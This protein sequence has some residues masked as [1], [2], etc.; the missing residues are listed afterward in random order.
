M[1]FD[2][3]R[4]LLAVHAHPDDESRSTGGVLALYA[5]QGVRVVLVMCTSGELGD[6]PG[7]IKPGDLDHHPQAVAARRRTQL[8]AACDVLGVTDLELLGYHDSGET[9]EVPPGAFCSIPVET[10]AG[11]VAALIEHYRPQV[12]VTHD[13]H[14]PHQ[15]RDHVH[16]ARVAHLAA[17]ETGIP[18]KLYLEAHESLATTTIDTSSVAELK[19]KAMYCY[20][21][22]SLIGKLTAGQRSSTESYTRAIDTTNAPLPETDLFAGVRHHGPDL[23]RW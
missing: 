6:M 18:A 17:K 4:T 21:S 19:R 14:N 15:H 22:Q 12:V 7:G 23:P 5:Q 11:R 8:F 13:H 20:E 1:Q 2:G 10:A 3:P 16:A 9:G